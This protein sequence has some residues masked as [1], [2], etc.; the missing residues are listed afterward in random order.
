MTD[1]G[2][3]LSTQLDH[4]IGAFVLQLSVPRHPWPWGE[5]ARASAEAMVW[6]TNSFGIIRGGSV[7]GFL[8]IWDAPPCPVTCPFH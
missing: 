6:M 2:F 3:H 7:L 5:V 4:A 1:R 8:L